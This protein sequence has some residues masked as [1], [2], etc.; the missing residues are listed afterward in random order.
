M[1]M[2]AGH[3]KREAWGKVSISIFDPFE[4]RKNCQDFLW[5]NKPS[6]PF[7]KKKPAGGGCLIFEVMVTPTRH[8]KQ[9][10]KKKVVCVY[11]I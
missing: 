7:I 8:S 11:D 10:K 3:S 9:F 6:N 5:K 1:N 4:S 2:T